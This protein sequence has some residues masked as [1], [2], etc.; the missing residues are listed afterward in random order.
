MV[1]EAATLLLI[2][3]SARALAVAARRAGYA[4]IA[5]D[6]FGDEDA[7]AACREMWVVENAVGGFA[8]LD[9]EPVV[10]R[11]CAAQAPVGVVFGSGF[12]DCPGALAP[13]ARY[14]PLIGWPIAFTR[15]KSPRWLAA[16]CKDAGIA[17]P[18]IR[19]AGPHPS[20][21]WLVKR[22]GG[23]GGTHIRPAGESRRLGEG[24]YWQRRIEGRAL[25]LLFVRD[26]LTLTPIGW[27]EQWTSPAPGAPFRYGG[28][29]GPLDFEPPPD[30]LQ[31]LASLT[32]WQ[33]VRGLASADFI[34]D[35]ERLWLLEINPRPGATLDVFDD[36]DDPL[37]ARHIA[38]LADGP[39]APAKP[40]APKA[41]EIV[42]AEAGVT[43]PGGDWP[44]GAA[45][46]PAMG[47]AIPPGA[48]VC[49]V[50]A[51]AGSVAEAKTLLRERV[52]RIRA[53]LSEGLR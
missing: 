17:H 28:A 34:D 36:D 51:G 35:G 4:A 2:A 23:S 41:A 44:E 31:K 3:V 50:S 26:P 29:A 45:D 15:A 43:I 8:G 32:L 12:D 10:A 42:Y 24:E 52:R 33:G 48:P 53:W 11:A 6:A 49:T 9:L 39:A 21:N 7:R 13:L 30:L 14:A 22:A 1:S 18:R 27:S 19:Y 38:A 5:I 25:S 20:G 40:R 37:L 47:A 46:R 16:D